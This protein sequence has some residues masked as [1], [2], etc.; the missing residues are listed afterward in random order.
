ML[1]QQTDLQ[2][3]QTV[4]TFSGVP[5]QSKQHQQELKQQQQTEQV[6]APEQSVAT[7]QSKHPSQSIQSVENHPKKDK[8]QQSRAPHKEHKE[9][10]AQERRND[11]QQPRQSLPGKPS[12]D[13]VQASPAPV[14]VVIGET[15]NSQKEQKKIHIS[16]PGSASQEQI[17]KNSVSSSN[18]QEQKR[19]KLTIVRK[20]E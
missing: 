4:F 16:R 10:K 7:E 17:I 18:T 3:Q 11:H 5:F 9:G 19:T 2:R 15:S 13:V 6:Q 1:R 8:K 20:Q 14:V 12:P